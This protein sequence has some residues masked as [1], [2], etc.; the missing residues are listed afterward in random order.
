V[1]TKKGGN[2]WGEVTPYAGVCSEMIRGEW[3]HWGV[4]RGEKKH[5]FA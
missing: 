3:G 1:F 4:E 2:V 5:N